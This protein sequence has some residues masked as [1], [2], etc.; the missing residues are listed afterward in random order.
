M[1]VVETP[2]HRKF[3][4]DKKLEMLKVGDYIPN[5]KI[6][7]DQAKELK[8]YDLVSDYLLLMC[9]STDCE[10]CLASMEALDEF[11]QENPGINIA[12]LLHTS[13][14]NFELMKAAFTDRIEHIYLVPKELIT[15]KLN[16]YFMPRGYAINKLGQVLSTNGCSDL[17]WFNKLMEPLRRILS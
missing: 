8:L 14:E 10:S 6:Y 7:E 2:A 1:S 11:T 3:Y 13:P 17:Y 5:V 15:R 12:V 16:V 4:K 9:Y